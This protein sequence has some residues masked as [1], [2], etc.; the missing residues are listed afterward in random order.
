MTMLMPA[1]TRQHK[2]SETWDL[3]TALPFSHL[4]YLNFELCFCFS[5]FS[6][7][8]F[9]NYA[10]YRCFSLFFCCFFVSYSYSLQFI[11][12]RKK[13]WSQAKVD[14]IC[15]WWWYRLVSRTSNLILCPRVFVVIEQKKDYKCLLHVGVACW[16][17]LAAIYLCLTLL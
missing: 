16:S 13:H 7:T 17:Y 1:T 12:W 14:S 2:L 9:Q 5:R 3:S 11:T 15:G 8:W 6:P 10:W 4:I